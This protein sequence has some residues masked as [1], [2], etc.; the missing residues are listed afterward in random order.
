MLHS[1]DEGVLWM[2]YASVG[3]GTFYVCADGVGEVSEWSLENGWN[4]CDDGSDELPD[5]EGAL[6]RVVLA[7][8]NAGG[9][10]KEDVNDDGTDDHCYVAE[11]TVSGD[12]GSSSTHLLKGMG[13]GFESVDLGNVDDLTY[14]G[15]AVDGA[16]HQYG[17]PSSGCWGASVADSRRALWPPANGQ[18]WGSEA[19]HQPRKHVDRRRLASGR[20]SF[21]AAHQD[22]ADYT[23]EFEL[24]DEMGNI[25]AA[26][27]MTVAPTSDD[28]VYSVQDS[29]Y[30]TDGLDAGEYCGTFE[31]VDAQ[32]VT[33][34]T[35]ESEDCMTVEELPEFLQTLQTIGEAF[36]E[37]NFESTWSLW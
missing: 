35:Y 23:L 22:P 25:E 1:S 33:V 29:M 37:S 30:L 12:D 24:L 8:V 3:V 20:V 21:E 31:L 27:Q 34:D 13:W 28:R 26:S 17:V 4:D 18:R 10:S 9:F 19:T 5:A 36:G 16:I 2:D 32:G 11:V 15:Y 14:R 7:T 6:E